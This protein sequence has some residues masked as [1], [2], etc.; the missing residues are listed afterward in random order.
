[1]ATLPGKGKDGG[2][3]EARGGRRERDA[4]LEPSAAARSAEASPASSAAAGELLESSAGLGGV[5]APAGNTE[6]IPEAAEDIMTQKRRS[7][8]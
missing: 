4:V 7:S 2:D 1:M 3:P 8:I 5:G 6:G